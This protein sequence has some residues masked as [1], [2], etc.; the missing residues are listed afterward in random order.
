VLGRF[1]TGVAVITTRCANDSVAGTTVNSVAPVSTE[2]PRL[3][4]S[5]GKNARSRSIYEG[6]EGFVV[7]ILSR[8]Q[9]DLA[10]RMA[11]RVPDRFAG[12]RWR[13]A[14]GSGMPL[15]EDCI[16]WIEC[17]RGPVTDLG[18]HIVFTGDIENAQ[19]R[20]G[21]PLLYSLG[22]YAELAH[23]PVPTER[24]GTHGDSARH[25]P[26]KMTSPPLRGTSSI[27]LSGLGVERFASGVVVVS[28]QPRGA[29]PKTAIAR[30]FNSVSLD[31]PLLL[32]CVNAADA[33]RLGLAAGQACGLNI[34]SWRQRSHL[35]EASSPNGIGDAIWDFG[36]I[37][38][39]PLLR[40]AA[41]NF[42][43]VVARRASQ[44]ENVLLVGEVA[45]IEYS[46]NDPA[47]VRFSDGIALTITCG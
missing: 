9:I 34:L 42:E 33:A 2:P 23:S 39:A 15:L 26:A 11:A 44:G 35:L 46:E 21:A 47:L 22:Q 5:L 18:D 29:P 25:R 38:G 10:R 32:W 19:W 40:G 36:D 16:G 28:V 45:G 1:P 30:A 3:L 7:N 14:P 4:W 20:D 37:L 17:R 6:A 13:P 24:E 27:E 8:N 41:A 43:V 12:V 31:P